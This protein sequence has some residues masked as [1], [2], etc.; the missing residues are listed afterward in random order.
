MRIASK[1][2]KGKKTQ[3]LVKWCDSD[4]KTWEPIKHLQ[5]CKEAIQTYEAS[6]RKGKG[7]LAFDYTHTRHI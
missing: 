2:G 3:Y 1:K 5:G 7:K 6:V 4:V